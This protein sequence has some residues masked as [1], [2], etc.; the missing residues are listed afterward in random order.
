MIVYNKKKKKKKIVSFLSPRRPELRRRSEGHRRSRLTRLRLDSRATR[1]TTAVDQ[2]G[3]D[4]V[5]AL[6]LAGRSGRSGGDADLHPPLA[7][8]LGLQSFEDF[9]QGQ[10]PHQSEHRAHEH[11]HKVPVQDDRTLAAAA[12]GTIQ[13]TILYK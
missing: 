9:A 8:L 3:Q 6:E 1:R 12:A 10:V 13:F 2:L 4:V 7:D 5:F 11:L